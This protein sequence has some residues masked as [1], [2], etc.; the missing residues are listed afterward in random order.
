MG[1]TPE[2]EE[3]ATVGEY[4]ADSVVAAC[5]VRVAGTSNGKCSPLP[6]DPPFA[7]VSIGSRVLFQRHNRKG[8]THRTTALGTP[9]SMCFAGVC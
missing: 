9:M 5:R 6:S 8:C 3:G 2:L 4:G 7:T 1:R